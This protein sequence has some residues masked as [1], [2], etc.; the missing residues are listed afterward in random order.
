MTDL[1]FIEYLVKKL[2]DLVTDGNEI[3][4]DEW[5]KIDDELEKREIPKI[6]DDY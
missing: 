2:W 4:D 6:T 3:T 1:Q 5:G